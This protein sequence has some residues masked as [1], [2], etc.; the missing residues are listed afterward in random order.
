MSLGFNICLLV[1]I[2]IVRPIQG[3]SDDIETVPQLIPVMTCV[4]LLMPFGM[5][6]AIWPIWGFWTLPYM[7]VI[8]LGYLHMLSFLPG[9]K[10]GTILFWMVM[11]A[12]ATL[13]HKIPHA[14][15][16]HSW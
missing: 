7:F 4:G 10:F 15:H 8:G 11:I 13:S 14:G 2:T 16:E 9:G 3:L 6:L 12:T 1:Y 5:I